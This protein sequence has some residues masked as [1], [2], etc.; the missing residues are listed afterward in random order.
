MEKEKESRLDEKLYKHAW[1][2]YTNNVHA[3]W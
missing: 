2:N 1:D 3:P